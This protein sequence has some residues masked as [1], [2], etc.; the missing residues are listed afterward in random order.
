[1]IDRNSM[2]WKLLTLVFPVI[3][4]ILFFSI[5]GTD[6]PASVWISYIFIHISYFTLPIIPF[7]IQRYGAR[8]DLVQPLYL[9]SS[10]YFGIELV[11]GI[12]FIYLRQENINPAF[13]IQV[14]LTGMFAAVFISNLIANNSTHD[15]LIKHEAEVNYI[16]EISSRVYV[17][18]DYMQDKEANRDIERTYDLLHSSPAKSNPDVFTLEQRAL[19]LVAQLETAVHAQQCDRVHEINKQLKSTIEERNRQLR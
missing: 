6:H 10:V 4:N 16:K 13:I 12:L 19:D 1:M 14:I 9:I 7:L 3:F 17:L 8:T 18:I 2:L 5:A 15:S 11:V